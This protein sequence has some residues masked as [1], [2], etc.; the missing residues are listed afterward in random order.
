ME[1][2]ISEENENILEFKI[3]NLKLQEKMRIFWN[4]S[5]GNCVACL[6]NGHGAAVSEI[7][8]FVFNIQ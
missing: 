8:F 4:W 3:R 2:K 6:A 1:F 7:D 5:P